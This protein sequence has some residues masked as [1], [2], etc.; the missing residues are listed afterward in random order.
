VVAIFRISKKY[1]SRLTLVLFCGVRYCYPISIQIGVCQQILV[2][3]LN[4]KFDENPLSDS[5]VV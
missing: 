5:S 2:N 1:K 3:R 4:I